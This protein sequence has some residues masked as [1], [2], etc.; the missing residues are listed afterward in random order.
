[1][2]VVVHRS[3]AI[4]PELLEPT[5]FTSDVEGLS[6]LLVV[7]L[8]HFNNVSHVSECRCSERRRIGLRLHPICEAS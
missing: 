8:A 7:Q 4:T 6:P 5:K 1:M 3:V 2:P